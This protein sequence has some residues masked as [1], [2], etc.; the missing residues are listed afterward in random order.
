METKFVIFTDDQIK[1][2]EDF[3]D[4]DFEKTD[5]VLGIK[6]QK[7]E[8]FD[9]TVLLLRYNCP[10]E[11]CEAA[12][13]GWPDLHR[14]VRNDHHKV[15]CDLCTRNKKVFTHEHE[16]FANQELRKHERF[17]DDNPGA[18]DQSGFKGHPECGFCRQRFYGDDE[19][20]THCREKHER[21]HICDRRLSG[22]QPQY[23]V[24]YDAL[25]QHF[26]KD[27]FLCLDPRC[28]EAKFVVFESEMDLK[29]HQLAEH[30]NTISRDVR[31]DV[32]TVDISSFD[33]RAP[34][35]E[36]RGRRGGRG[37]RGRDPNSEPPPPSSAQPLRRDELAYQ[38]QME[39]QSAQ[40]TRTRTFGGQ[41]TSNTDSRGRGNGNQRASNNNNNNNNNGMPDLESLTINNTHQNSST[42]AD[43]APTLQEQARQVQH[44]A[45]ISRACAML[46]NDQTKIADFRARVSAYRTSAITATQMIDTSLTLFDSKPSDLG[47]LIKELAALYES[48][49]K[50][51]ALLKAWNDWRAINEDYPS[52]PG[53][54]GGSQPST[55]SSTS[56]NRRI[57]KLKSSTA[58]SSRSATNRQNSWGHAAPPPSSSG[59]AGPRVG[60]PASWNAP[61]AGRTM[62]ASRSAAPAKPASNLEAFPA[63]PAAAK[64]NTSIWGVHRGNVRWDDRR[65]VPSNPWAGGAAAG[66]AVGEAD[67]GEEQEEPSTTSRKKK[68]KKKQTL[69]KFG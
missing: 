8:I 32:R 27:H 25:E 21:C 57:L 62:T 67:A 45:V 2:Y 35:T 31:R 37:G 26:R 22:R 24:N 50:R 66:G 38:R 54:S 56:Q 39:I 61:A 52:L 6:Y 44:D 29:A 53:P 34:Y 55:T 47:T 12:C 1:H 48:E 15:M 65:P 60:A 40:S 69:Y 18:V 41:L 58:Q 68:G 17:G 23:Y 63:L 30:S 5:E 11:Q 19:L 59:T 28:Q 43:A 3:V 9:D 13:F 51:T 46:D 16:L 10:E 20:F 64:P 33:Y 36:N 49:A 14:H 7:T 42:S 4:Q